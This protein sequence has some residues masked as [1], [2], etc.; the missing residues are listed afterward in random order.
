M[1]KKNRKELGSRHGTSLGQNKAYVFNSRE[2]DE[3]HAEK[4]LKGA[5][6]MYH[7]CMICSEMR[8]YCKLCVVENAADM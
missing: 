8:C 3:L 1:N 7:V 6:C 4:F 2:N 5:G